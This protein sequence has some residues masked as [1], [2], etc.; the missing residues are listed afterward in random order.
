[1]IACKQ[2]CNFKRLLSVKNSVF[3]S[4]SENQ[5][6][7]IVIKYLPPNAKLLCQS[8]FKTFLNISDFLDDS[9]DVSFLNFDQLNKLT[10]NESLMIAKSLNNKI[11]EKISQ[12]IIKLIGI[13]IPDIIDATEIP[14]IASSIPLKCFTNSDPHKIAESLNLMDL[15]NMNSFRKV[16][17]AYKV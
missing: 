1:M 11:D 7:K 12:L 4:I 14:S 8:V 17:L 13:N 3:T 6:F 10:S 15:E 9:G 5:F 16:F 2:D